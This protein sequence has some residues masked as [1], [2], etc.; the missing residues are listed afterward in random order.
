MS[1]THP[2][3]AVTGSSGAGTSTLK[4]V[5]EDIFHRDKI[6][7]V[8]ID[9]DSFHRYDRKQMRAEVI[10]AEEKGERLTHFS[11]KANDLSRLEQLFQSYS[12]TGK[13][14]KRHYIHNEVA[15]AKFHQA[16]GTF[17]S[18]Q[19]FG[20]DNDL[21]LYTGLHGGLVTAELNIA[22]YVDLLIG[23]VPIINL[24]WI[25]KIKRDCSNR[26]YSPEAVVDNILKRMPDYAHYIT[27]QFSR[28]DINFQ[29]IPLIDVS[30]PFEA[31]EIPAAEESLVVIRFK[32]P[33]VADFPYY[34]EMLS[35]S[36]M[37]RA[38]SIVVPEV[39]MGL[40]M[41]IIVTPFINKIMVKLR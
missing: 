22:K 31:R 34:L 8:M 18:W 27:P 12:V 26:G 11:P 5:F 35:N 9:G 37:S 28:T 32:D 25:Q 3:I 40:A 29:R 13:G 14:E 21:L 2:I 7:P 1:I 41:E 16:L 39:E 10:K 4:Q 23:V 20:D 19:T 33:A 38:D 24:E 36:F 30:N 17:T 15:S 6:K